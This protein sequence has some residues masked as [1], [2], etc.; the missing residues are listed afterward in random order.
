MGWFQRYGLLA[1]AAALLGALALLRPEVPVAPPRGA[2]AEQRPE[3]VTPAPEARP[4]SAAPTAVAPATVH[5]EAPKAFAPTERLSQ[6]LAELDGPL[7]RPGFVA[8]LL[9]YLDKQPDR[10]DAA[11]GELV[12]A[13]KTTEPLTSALERWLGRHGPRG[14]T[15]LLEALDFH[16]A[17]QS[18]KLA[19]AAEEPRR[20]TLT[21]ALERLEE[22]RRELELSITR[23]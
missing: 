11:L 2:D 12:E 23:P 1:V 15:A 20:R 3:I 10:A 13:L 14:R 19:A 21:R 17:R 4:A 22:L 6:I 7:T 5:A 9:G 8:D 16:R 18:Q